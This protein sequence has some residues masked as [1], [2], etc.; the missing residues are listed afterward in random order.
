MKKFPKILLFLILVGSLFICSSYTGLESTDC[1]ETEST[2]SAYIRVCD[3]E[4]T[5]TDACG[6]ALTHQNEFSGSLNITD[7]EHLDEMPG[8]IGEYRLEVPYS[9]E[10]R[11][12]RLGETPE[13]EQQIFSISTIQDTNLAEYSVSGTSIEEITIDFS[14]KVSFCG[15]DMTFNVFLSM[16]CNGLGEKGCIR[17]YGAA[18]KEAHFK[19]EGDM[20]KF[21]GVEPETG[22]ISYAGKVSNP[23]VYL[24]LETGE[25]TIDL[26]DV[27]EGNILITTGKNTRKIIA[28][29]G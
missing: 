13:G 4:F 21:S 8:Y 18:N 27:G 25:G 2:A 17:F 10:F 5:I 24:A 12:E 20:I 26:S 15:N 22:A 7:Q 29:G 23:Y 28:D 6:N 3:T 1:L 16:P 19:I 9:D 11:Y 14:G